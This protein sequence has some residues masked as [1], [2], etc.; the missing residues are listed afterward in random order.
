VPSARY[1]NTGNWFKGN[2]HLH[3]TASDG[4]KTVAELERMYAGAGYDFLCLTDHWV[5]SDLARDGRAAG[6]P[7]LW[8]D[9]IELHGRDH[10]GSQYHVVC[11][12]TLEGISREM[13]FIAAMEAARSQGALLILAHPHWMG[14]SFEDALRWGFHGVETYNHVCHWLN[15]K[16]NGHAYWSAMLERFPNTLGFAVD[17]AHLRPEHPGWNGGWIMVA[18]EACT[19][20]AILD[21]IRAG[22]FYATCGPE[23]HTI[24]VEGQRVRIETSPVQFARLVGPA[25][26]GQRV[27][28]F[29]G[30]VFEEVAFDIPEEWAYAYLEIEDARGRR[31]WTNPLFAA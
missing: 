17:D 14:N 31:A 30:R 3:S 13:G 2:T 29:D 24:E 8:L 11:L 7:V 9:G 5:A 26:W 19:R 10:G 20:E 15:G 22:R 28:S 12:G 21:A 25:S 4:G 1:G 18:A 16:G 23:F 6:A 27:G